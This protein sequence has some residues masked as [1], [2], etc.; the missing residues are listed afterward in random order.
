MKTY[1]SVIRSLLADGYQIAVI[2]GEEG[3]TLLKPSNKYADIV[4][5]VESMDVTS[6]EV[7]DPSAEKL[8]DKPRVGESGAGAILYSNRYDMPMIG[9]INIILDNDNEDDFEDCQDYSGEAI[10]KTFIKLGGK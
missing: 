7:F 1:K 6:V 5:H 8:I 2:D 9:W 4:E 3:Q 10:E